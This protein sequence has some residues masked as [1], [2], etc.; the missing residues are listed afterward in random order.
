MNI[1]RAASPC[2]YKVGHYT[3]HLI[4]KL[5]KSANLACGDLVWKSE[6]NPNNSGTIIYICLH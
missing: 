5:S 1:N 3:L 6:T 4:F 2:M